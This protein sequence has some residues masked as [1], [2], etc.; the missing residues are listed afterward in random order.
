MPRPAHLRS[1]ATAVPEHVLTQ[2]DVRAFAAKLFPS[3]RSDIDRLQPVYRNAGIATRRSCV[4]IE[5]YGQAHGWKERSRLYVDNAVALAAE[6]AD[7][8]LARAGVGVE[9]IDAIVAVSTSGVSTPSLD[10]LLIDRLGLR[11]DVLR[12]PI[13]GLGCGGGVAG[14]AR[15]SMIARDTPATHILL[16]VVE[17]CGLTFRPSDH[18]KSN[19]VATALFG[20]GAA[21]AVLSTDGGGPALLDWGEYTWPDSLD[22]M[23]W[24]VE[25]DGFGVLFSRDIPNLVTTEYRSAL[26][27]YLAT[28]GHSLDD[29]AGFICHPGGAKV[30][31]ALERSLNVPDGSMLVARDILRDYGNMSAAT[32]LF[33]LERMADDGLDGRY[34]MSALGPGFTAS[35]LTL[36]A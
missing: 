4:P 13:F 15:A 17:L 28:N 27:S 32:V 33:V 36:A 12:L 18:S 22:V 9:D 30:V 2:D 10:A 16:V 29:Y 34:L 1:I 5:W 21:A 3:S 20:D 25:D 11:R 35:F 6:A 19:I 23:G 7:R 8:A 14:L 26:S 31:T 24:R